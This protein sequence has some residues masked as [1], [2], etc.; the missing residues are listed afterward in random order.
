LKHDPPF[1]LVFAV[2]LA[3]TAAGAGATAAS[4]V[5]SRR[6]DRTITQRAIG[7]APLGWS[8]TRY[9]RAFGRPVRLERLEASLTRLVFTPLDVEVYL[10]RGTGVAITTYGRAYRTPAGV[11]PCSTAAALTS[12]YG[13][14]LSRLPTTGPIA[15]YRLGNLVFRV[16]RRYG[17]VEAVTLGR[18]ALARL[19][20]GNSAGCHA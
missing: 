8:Q 2:T 20:A 10:R 19:I 14:R 4:P 16:D 5:E 11:G 13:G 18:G 1:G 15:L 7:G 9:V 6:S 3:L 12:A 17:R